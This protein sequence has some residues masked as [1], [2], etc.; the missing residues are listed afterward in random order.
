VKTT[1]DL[2][3][4]LVQALKLRSV[5]ERRKLKDV[6]AA[7]LRRGLEIAETVPTAAAPLPP[8]LYLNE[9]GFPLI[10]C[11]PDSPASKMTTV[12]LLQLEKDCLLLEDLQR[13]GIT[14]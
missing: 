4:D 9:H 7:A 3:D 2:P 14:D 12:Q 11:G 10:R 8:S 6:A 13:V 1:L 5:H